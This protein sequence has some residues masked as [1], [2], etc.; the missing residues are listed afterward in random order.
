MTPDTWPGCYAGTWD[1]RLAE[2][3]GSPPI[4]WETVQCFQK[5]GGR[6]AP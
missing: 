5:H 1:G 3:K 2:A 6:R 4:D